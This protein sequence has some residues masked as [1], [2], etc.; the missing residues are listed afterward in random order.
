MMAHRE[1]RVK[2]RTSQTMSSSRAIEDMWK[3][4]IGWKSKADG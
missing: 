4:M 2:K 3:H 1:A